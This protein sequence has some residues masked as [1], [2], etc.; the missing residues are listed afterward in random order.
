MD[1]TRFSLYSRAYALLGRV[2]PIAADCGR[3]CNAKC[4]AGDENTGMI[5]FPGECE[6]IS[7]ASFLNIS[8]SNMQGMEI[9]FATCNGVCKRQL[10]PLS[11]RIFPLAPFWNG[12]E[13][14]IAP[15]PRAKF[16]CPL[17]DAEEFISKEFY[18]AVEEAFS[19]LVEDAEISD[20]LIHYTKMLEEYL[21]FSA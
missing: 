7:N 14:K 10:R 2:T 5:L 21:V 19:L 6:F 20:M 13:L 12:E 1:S 17:L 8:K 11:C 3:L 16:L 18:S 9:D 15:D 4:C